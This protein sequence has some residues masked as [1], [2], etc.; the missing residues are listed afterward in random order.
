ML[1]IQVVSSI[2][3]AILLASDTFISVTFPAL[4]KNI[5]KQT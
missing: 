5:F 1:F 3:D 2:W 4:Q